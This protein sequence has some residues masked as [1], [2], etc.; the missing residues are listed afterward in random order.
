MSDKTWR[1]IIASIFVVYVLLRLWNLSDSCLWFDEIFSVH[2]AEL[3]WQNLVR[4]VGQDLIHPPLFYFL[5][6]I[7]IYIGG[8]NLFWLRF[9]PVFFSVLAVVPFLLL[10]RELKLN[11]LIVALA[12]T[13]FAANG[14]LIK[15]AQEVRMYS[16]VLF[17]GLFSMWF[18]ARLFNRGKNLWF[19]TLIN[20]LLVYTHY[21]G[22]FVVASEVAAILIL[23]RIKARQILLML[24]VTALSFAPWI[25]ALW[26]ASKINSN[27][28]Q[29]IGWMTK[30]NFAI[31]LQFVF[32]LFE[33]I[34]FEQSSA[35]KTVI[36]LI[37]LP[38][39]AI[40]ILSFGFYLADWKSETK[41]DKHKIYLLLIFIFVPLLA[42][43]VASWILPYSIWGTRH[44]LIVFAPTQILFAIALAKIRF[45]QLK[46]VVL[47]LIFLLFGAAFLLQATRAEPK[48][49]W[50]AWE[51]LALSLQQTQNGLNK[52]TKIYVFEDLVAYH[53]WFALR[54]SDSGFQV[55][56]VNAIVGLTEDKA[57]FLPRGF[58]EVQTINENEIEGERIFI[59]FRDKDWNSQKPP[60][61]NLIAKG[62]KIGEPRILEAQGLK[63]FLVEVGK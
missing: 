35:D 24:A 17:F 13:F 4:L 20:I 21:F 38:I 30:P 33:P 41:I 51:N 37:T 18:F 25:F 39:L 22:W 53:F 47:S 49:I 59:A 36:F 7:W 12:L 11:F 10:C 61:R 31:V 1:V 6:K 19:L 48:Y 42:A 3:D 60:L 9:F 58:D 50:C 45:W 56:K 5:L 28:A 40:V 2:V 26:Q 52:P 63:A 54:D 29:N 32:D 62:Y 16:L 57:Y 44:L 15:Y 55:V 46:T 8:E 43:F 23:Q 27:V 34:Y 14:S